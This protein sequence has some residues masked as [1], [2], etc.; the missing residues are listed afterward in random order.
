MA[1]LHGR[2]SSLQP[3][4]SYKSNLLPGSA[5][6]MRSLPSTQFFIIGQMLMTAVLHVRSS[7]L[8][9][10]L[11]YKSNLF[12]G[13]AAEMRSLPSTQFF[14]IGQ[15]LMTQCYSEGVSDEKRE[16]RR[17]RLRDRTVVD[18][19]GSIG[20]ADKTQENDIRT[21]SLFD[22][23]MKLT[24]LNIRLFSLWS[25]SSSSI[26]EI[27]EYIV[28]IENLRTFEKVSLVA[29]RRFSHYQADSRSS[30]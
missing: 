27:L 8:Q 17:A 18:R 24:Q 6:E 23:L 7:S 15:M 5:A 20:G 4:L 2:S 13:S 29:E 26:D 16:R 12:P 14:I 21:K 30:A 11:S 28:Q 1:V 3:S 25:S 22:D 19:L 9:P 10:S